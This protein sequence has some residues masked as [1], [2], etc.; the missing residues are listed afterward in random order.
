MVKVPGG[1]RGYRRKRSPR[2]SAHP[3]IWERG[4]EEGRAGRLEGEGRHREPSFHVS[5][6]WLVCA[7]PGQGTV[8]S[9]GR[10]FQGVTCGHTSLINMNE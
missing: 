7:W 4:G 8:R 9:R 6:T 5:F 1:A 10:A 3:G 2:V